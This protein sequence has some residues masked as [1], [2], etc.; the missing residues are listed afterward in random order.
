MLPKQIPF[1][2]TNILRDFLF[3]STAVA[4]G[5]YY[6]EETAWIVQSLHNSWLH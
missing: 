3:F 2:K 4:Q 1:L 6:Y 5:W